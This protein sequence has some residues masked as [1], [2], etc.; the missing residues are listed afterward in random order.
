MSARRIAGFLLSV[1][2]S[3]ALLLLLMRGGSWA[4]L[5]AS[6]ARMPRPALALYALVSA[7]GL[8]LRACRF[9]LLLPQPRPAAGKLLLVTAAQNC[10]GDLVPGRVAALGTYVYLLVRRLGVGAEPAA[11]TFLLSV[12]FEVATLGP[13]L[14]LAALVR[15]DAG[16]LA[17]TLPIG[18]IVG[19]GVG[20]FL[21]AAVVVRELAPLTSALARVVRGRALDPAPRA[22]SPRQALALRLDAL[23]GALGEARRAGTLAPVFLLS[24]LIRLAKYASLY[25]LM[26]GLL[27]GAGAA[28]KRPDFWDLILGITAT[29]LVASLPIPAL[30]QFGVWEGGMTG[31]LLLLGF[32]RGTATLAA[33]GI[34]GIAQ[35]YEYV[36][37]LVALGLLALTG[38]SAGA[39]AAT[40]PR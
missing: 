29:E 1:A 11:A 9:R 20:L 16:G 3:V 2:V 18:W 8:L 31:A 38:A 24:L 30:G 32:E 26:T 12:V 4:A 19:A 28:G 36:L 5:G 40:A 27:D 21:A 15:L 39:D 23:A 22:R 25:A 14:A 35:A 37:G 17:S 33:V 13:V 10:L 7:G 34:H 6:I